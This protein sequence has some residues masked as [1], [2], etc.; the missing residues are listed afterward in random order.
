MLSCLTV[1]LSVLLW[2][3]SQQGLAICAAG[4]VITAAARARDLRRGVPREIAA[5]PS[6]CSSMRLP[7]PRLSAKERFLNNVDTFPVGALVRVPMRGTQ[8]ENNNFGKFT[9]GRVLRHPSWDD[10]GLGESSCLC[11]RRELTQVFRSYGTA[12]ELKCGN[13]VLLEGEDHEASP[14]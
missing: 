7:K 14:L 8:E 6:H 4:G 2:I 11:G 5:K 12:R 1:V 9:E 10:M 13:G 3:I